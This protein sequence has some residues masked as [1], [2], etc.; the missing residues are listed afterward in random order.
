MNIFEGDPIVIEVT[1]ESFKEAVM[2]GALDVAK[3]T[4]D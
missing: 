2:Y 3:K 4:Y 1:T